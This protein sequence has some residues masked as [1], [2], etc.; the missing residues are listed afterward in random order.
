LGM[1]GAADSWSDAALHL[2]LP[3]ALHEPPP[4]DEHEQA[5]I[6]GEY[7]PRLLMHRLHYLPEVRRSRSPGCELTFPTAG[8]ARNLMACVP[9][10]PELEQT[11]APVL[12]SQEQDILARRLWDPTAAIIQVVWVLLHQA[13][14][15]ASTTHVTELTN[16]LLR[17][18]GEILTYSHEE[19]GRKLSDLGL[20]RSRGRNCMILR[21]SRELS[22]HIHLLARKFE[23][24]VPGT[25]T[26]P[27]CAEQEVIA[28]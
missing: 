11:V 21:F 9:H 18:R 20:S 1:E 7:Q 24:N 25:E 4:L 10:S 8:L 28:G 26:C 16:T 5:R 13:V 6:A 2:A 14:R 22:R 27:D 17:S 3:P 12:Q 23:L 15:E 19:I